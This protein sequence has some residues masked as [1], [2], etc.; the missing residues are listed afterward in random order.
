MFFDTGAQISYF[1]SPSLKDFPSNGT[2]KD[3]YPAIGEFETETYLLD[4]E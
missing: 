3:F 2:V 4:L 1:Q